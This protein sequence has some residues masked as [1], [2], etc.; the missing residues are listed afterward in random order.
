MRHIQMLTSIRV[1]KI[2]SE[3]A[4]KRLVIPRTAA[5]MVTRIARP[6]DVRRAA[7]NAP[8]WKTPA[9]STVCLGI[10]KKKP[11]MIFLNI[12]F[13]KEKKKKIFHRYINTLQADLHFHPFIRM[14]DR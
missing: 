7:Y 12:T 13:E 8:Y 3:I 4:N 5:P 2:A 9:W 11:S 1:S 14:N 6:S 10:S